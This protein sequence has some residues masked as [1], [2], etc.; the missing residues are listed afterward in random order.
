MLWTEVEI[1]PACD[2]RPTT[3]PTPVVHPSAVVRT[4]RETDGVEFHRVAGIE[5]LAGAVGA[6][7]AINHRR[8][9]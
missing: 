9:P 7:D 4:L 5:R 2:G 6:L 8:P 3:A 1:E